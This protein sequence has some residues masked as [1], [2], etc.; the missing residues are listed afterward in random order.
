MP[1]S[2]CYLAALL[3]LVKPRD[4]RHAAVDLR[5]HPLFESG[6]LGRLAFVVPRYVRELERLGSLDVVDADKK[7]GKE[8]GREKV[9]FAKLRGEENGSESGD[10]ELI[11]Q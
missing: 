2:F 7:L 6:L 8:R 1:P 4:D 3:A 11:Y 9:N 10:G 5:L